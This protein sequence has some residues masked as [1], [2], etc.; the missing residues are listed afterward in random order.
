MVD[1]H[2]ST[3]GAVVRV[4]GRSCVRTHREA[5]FSLI[6]L[7]IVLI[8]LAII[9]AIALP[10]VR[11]ASDGPAAPATAIAAGTVWRE[12]QLARVEAGGILPTTT[13][14][15]N[16]AAGLVD[17]AGARRIQPWPE[18]GRGEPINIAV[19][20]GGQPTSGPPNS[21]LYGASG[22][23]PTTGFLLGFGP[24]GNVVFKRVV[25]NGQ[26]VAGSQQAA[27]AG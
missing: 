23:R 19:T 8:V 16:R 5:G 20:T 9:A 17:A 2:T 1:A 13:Q 11:T 18:T 3:G 22:A 27:S 26:P 6:E 21:L 10:N 25:A 7:L 24:K 14:L 15:Q 4:H 12:I